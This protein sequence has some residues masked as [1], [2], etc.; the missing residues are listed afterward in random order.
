[1]LRFYQLREMALCDYASG[2]NAAEQRGIAIGEQ[3]GEQRGIT[4]GEQRGEQRGITIGEQKSKA[5]FVI[6]LSRNGF[7]IEEISKYTMTTSE[8]VKKILEEKGL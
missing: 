2:I 6:N 5:E 7:S 1:M 8:E 4:I 3:R